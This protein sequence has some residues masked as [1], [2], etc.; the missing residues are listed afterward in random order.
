MST[1][2][3]DIDEGRYVY[4]TQSPR[5]VR[6]KPRYTDRQKYCLQCFVGSVLYIGGIVTV[7]TLYYYVYIE[8][9]LHC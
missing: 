6:Q 2:I 9:H 1:P 8:P 4:L 5:P 7:G 3:I